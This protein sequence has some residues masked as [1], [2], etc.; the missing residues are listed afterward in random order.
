MGE[1]TSV[2][3]LFGVGGQ[4]GLKSLRQLLESRMV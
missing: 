3:F 4:E 1:D 2:A